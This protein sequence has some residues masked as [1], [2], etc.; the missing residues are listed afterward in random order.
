MTV[1]KSK[2]SSEP[3]KKR[4]QLL[5]QRLDT[6]L[7]RLGQSK[8]N[9]TDWSTVN[10]VFASIALA[11]ATP[12]EQGAQLQSGN[13]YKVTVGNR[14]TDPIRL[15]DRFLWKR[16]GRP[17]VVM[18]IEREIDADATGDDVTFICHATTQPAGE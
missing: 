10:T 18:S 5:H 16:P 4:H 7:T 3:G 14:R 1:S 6:E 11:G 17:I 2:R 13:T 9:S 15:E 12:T 8:R